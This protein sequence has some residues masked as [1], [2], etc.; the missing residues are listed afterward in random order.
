MLLVVS[1]YGI[2][3]GT[4]STAGFTWHWIWQCGFYLYLCWVQYAQVQVLLR[5]DRK[6]KRQTLW[7]TRVCLGL[8][9][10]LGLDGASRSYTNWWLNVES[11]VQ[12]LGTALAWGQGEGVFPKKFLQWTR[13]LVIWGEVVYLLLLNR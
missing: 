1:S 7:V 9:L 2:P 11:K 13:E 12:G 8:V 10:G 4:A 3:V 6:S 5:F